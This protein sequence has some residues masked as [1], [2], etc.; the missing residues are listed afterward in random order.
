MPIINDITYAGPARIPRFVLQSMMTIE[1]F[2]EYIG[3]E[4]EF[5]LQVSG[6]E[7]I[8]PR[9]ARFGELDLHP[10]IRRALAERGVDQYYTHQA[11][12][13]GHIRAG[14]NV[15]LMTPT[16]SGKSLAYNIPVL[17]SVLEDPRSAA[18]YIYPLKGLEQD[19]LRNLSDLAVSIGLQNTGQVYDGDTPASQRRKIR[20]ELPNVIFTN[21]DMLHLALL[22]F[23]RKWEGLFRNLKFVVVDEVHSYRGVFGTHVAQIFRRLRRVCGH[24]GSSPQFIAASATVSNPSAHAANLTGLDFEV[25]QESG[26]PSSGRHFF[27][28]NPIESPYTVSTRLFVR[29]MQEG[30]RTIL[31]T[32]ARKITE[33][34][35]TWAGQYVPELL[36]KDRKSVV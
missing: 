14:R 10:G 34:I 31:F 4:R 32:K 3:G 1:E 19:Q 36:S 28:V 27:F 17:E 33:L 2:I 18:L 12:A 25:V 6:H 29:C 9:A 13:I 21:P 23:H 8:P 20:E 7:Y 11:E 15:L 22:P 16:A 5:Q 24:Y 30:V 35:Y 26:A